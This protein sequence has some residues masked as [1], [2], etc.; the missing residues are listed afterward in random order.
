MANRREDGNI[1][2]T[3]ESPKSPH[4]VWTW[5]THTGIE[6]W[7]R[8]NQG[9]SNHIEDSFGY[10][11][12]YTFLLKSKSFDT[13]QR[14]LFSGETRQSGKVKHQPGKIDFFC[15]ANYKKAQY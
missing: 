10:Y 15:V 2:R 14:K 4:R 8:G 3:P 12:I 5:E 11:F 1:A 7:Q 9:R 13:I 6:V